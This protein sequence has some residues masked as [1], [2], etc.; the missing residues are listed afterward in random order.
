V[1]ADV[2]AGVSTGVGAAVAAGVI[3]VTGTAATGVAVR[4]DV[5]RGVGVEMPAGVREGAVVS[6]AEGVSVGPI[7]GVI[8][9]GFVTRTT[10]TMVAGWPLG[11]GCVSDASSLLATCE[12][13]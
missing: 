2:G 13:L 9:L 8:P 6:S 7:G 12:I 4:G 3:V 10:G 11:C 5:G 1:G